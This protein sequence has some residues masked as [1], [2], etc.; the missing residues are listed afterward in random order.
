MNNRKKAILMVG[1]LFCLNLSIFSQA[2]SIKIDNV[3]VKEAITELKEKSGYSFVFATG[4]L[5][6][7]KN[8]NV[9]ATQLEEAIGQILQGQ[10]VTYEIKGKNIIIKRIN[11]A[12]ATSDQKKRQISGIV[13]DVNGEPVIGANIVDK[14]E[15]TNGTITNVDGE[16][17]LTVSPDAVLVVS[18]IGYDQQEVLVKN[19]TSL[20]IIL[21]ENT[22]LIDEVIVIGYGSVKK[23]NLTSS[24]SKITDDAIKDRPVTTLSEAFQGQLAGVQAQATSGGIPGEEMT[25]RIRGVNT[26]N[27]DSSPL[28]VIDGVPRDNMNGINPTDISS[29]QILK[30][31]SATSIYG[32]RGANGVVLIE[33]KQG[34]GKP[35]VTFDAY[36]GLQTPETKL[37]LMNGNEWVAYNTWHRNVNYV[38]TGG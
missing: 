16:F 7:K 24:V 13:K 8:V 21:E 5:D 28:Y 6:T 9:Q 30:D 18:Y 32:S 10:N 2:V 31:A 11:E 17:A 20:R 25:I 22:R 27:G 35:T 23:T 34:T 36:Y 26:V 14:N 15:V 19:N 1:A 33:T 12:P 4:D 29:I 38:R 37:D 3:S